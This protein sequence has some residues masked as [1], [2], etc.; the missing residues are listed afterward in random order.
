MTE[1]NPEP[2]DIIFVNRGLYRH[3]GVYVGNNRVVHFAAKKEN[4]TN[5]KDAHI[6]E[7][8]LS[9]FIRGDVLEIEPERHGQSIFFAVVTVARA[10]SLVGQGKGEYNLVFNNCE[11]FAYWCKYGRKVSKQVNNALGTT[12][13]VAVGLAGLAA[14]VAIAN[15]NKNNED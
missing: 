14:A 3:Y 12:A 4:E 9:Y 15:K 8:D 6:Q 10:K 1:K 7:T 5:A 2:G 11:H 13:A